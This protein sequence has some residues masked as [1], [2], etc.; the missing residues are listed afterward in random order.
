MLQKMYSIKYTEFHIKLLHKY[1]YNY[2]QYLTKLGK[3][4]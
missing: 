1:Y 2:Y 4:L 3:Q